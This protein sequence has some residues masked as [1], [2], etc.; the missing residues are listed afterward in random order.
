M[1]RKEVSGVN[2]SHAVG[3]AGAFFTGDWAAERMKLPFILPILQ[4]WIGGRAS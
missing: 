2:F 3:R 4:L 1:G